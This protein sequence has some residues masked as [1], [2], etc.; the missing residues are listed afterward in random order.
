MGT[1]GPRLSLPSCSCCYCWAGLPAARGDSYIKG[2]PHYDPAAP[3]HYCPRPGL[4]TEATQS[5]GH[6]QSGPEGR[7]TPL[8]YLKTCPWS[9]GAG[10]TLGPQEGRQLFLV[11][12]QA[13]VPPHW[14]ESIHSHS[15]IFLTTFGAVPWAGG[16]S[17][18][19]IC[20]HSYLGVTVCQALI[21]FPH[22]HSLLILSPV[23]HGVKLRHEEVK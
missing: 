2:A 20:P 18:P 1:G 5:P 4:R 6:S 16:P 19:V 8:S 7:A 15:R 9:Q 21:Y 22:T 3:P 11:Q 17:L 14:W 12:I 10:A 13:L 23:F